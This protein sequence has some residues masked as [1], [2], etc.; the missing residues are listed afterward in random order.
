M[1]DVLEGFNVRCYGVLIHDGKAL[2]S[3]ETVNG[4]ELV[5]FPGGGLEHLEAPADCLVR[6]FI[7]ELN[8]TVAVRSV[9][10]VSESMH[11]SYFRSQQMIGLYWYVEHLGELE[12]LRF[13]ERLKNKREVGDQFFKWVALDE[14]SQVPWTHD[15]DREVAKKCQSEK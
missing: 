6:E 15:L 12:E 9:C 8:L 1:N 5:K 3:Y 2:V 13:V 7:E 4:V 14:L 10:H 11:M